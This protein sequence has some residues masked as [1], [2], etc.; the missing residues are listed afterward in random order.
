MTGHSGG[1]YLTL[2]LGLRRPD[3]F[4]GICGRS[5]VYFKETVEFGELDKFEPDYELM[6]L[7]EVV[8]D[9]KFLSSSSDVAA[10]AAAAIPFT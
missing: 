2:W 6:S 3:L 9:C 5:C 1:T 8:W 4:L 10:A 7:D